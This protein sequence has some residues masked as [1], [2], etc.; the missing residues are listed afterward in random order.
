[1][2]RSPSWQLSQRQPSGPGIGITS[3]EFSDYKFSDRSLAKLRFR[4]PM[5]AAGR[6]EHQI[7]AAALDALTCHLH[8]EHRVL[9]QLVE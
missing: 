9:E 3:G 8:T 6:I 7:K 4:E 1:V 2:Y 5:P